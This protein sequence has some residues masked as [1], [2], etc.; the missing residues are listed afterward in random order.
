VQGQAV[1]AVLAVLTQIPRV[2]R[3]LRCARLRAA[4]TVRRA[5]RAAPL[6]PPAR[7]GGGAGPD[8]RVG[9]HYREIDMLRIYEVVLLM[10]AGVARIADEIEPKD[11]KLA[12]QLR[13]AVQ[14]VALNTAEGMGNIGGHKRQRYQ[15]ALGSAR[16]T[17]ACIDVATSMGYI[18]Q[19]DELTL[20]RLSHVTGT[21]V[22]LAR[23]RF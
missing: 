6:H 9:G 23:R 14:S 2:A 17:K 4:K 15:T 1:F 7:A 22:K 20:D 19:V 11:V 3:Y 16:E 12:G 21:L 18:R 5:E 10:V 13:E 8:E